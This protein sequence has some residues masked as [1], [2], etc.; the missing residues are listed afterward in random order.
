MTMTPDPIVRFTRQEQQ[1]LVVGLKLSAYSNVRQVLLSTMLRENEK[2]E[3]ITQIM[4]EAGHDVAAVLR[5]TPC[6]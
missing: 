5:R 3:R 6:D 2:L 4:Q 1:T